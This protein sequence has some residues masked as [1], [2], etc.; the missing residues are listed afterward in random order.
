M[1][2]NSFKKTNYINPDRTVSPIF[3]LSDYHENADGKWHK[4]YRIQFLHVS[5]GVLT[6]LTR[7]A[8]YVIPPNRAVWI[9]AGIEHCIKAR[10]KFWLT[11][12]YLEPELIKLED[13]IN[14]VAVDRL[15]NELLIEAAKFGGNYP[16]N[17]PETRL[18]SVLLDRL[19]H[20]L[21][22]DIILPEPSDPR[23]LHITNRLI[24]DPSN[25][26]SLASL[27]ARAALTERTAARLFV[28]DTGLTF[29]NWRLHMKLQYALE[30]LAAG[31]SVTETAFELGYADVSSF[32]SAFK[33]IFGTTP[34]RILSHKS[35]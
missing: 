29:G 26:E 8:R 15:T 3:V 19:P 27:A 28:K 12:C 18:I 5:A 21:K 31:S 35:Y 6:V 9:R 2:S 13:S 7:N 20:L 22:T 23:L 33:I 14:V 11:T 24:A 4:H 17:G 1:T 10:S 30:C 16:E 25:N 32:I 34:S